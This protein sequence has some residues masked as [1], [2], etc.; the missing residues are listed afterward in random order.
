VGFLC[1]PGLLGTA[2]MACAL[3]NA[4][5]QLGGIYITSL[6]R[7]LH[8]A[9]SSGD[10]NY[11]VQPHRST[12]KAACRPMADSVLPEAHDHAARP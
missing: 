3:G 4:F 10:L 7:H 2:T 11:P 9:T 1:L 5:K 8:A 12:C 6:S